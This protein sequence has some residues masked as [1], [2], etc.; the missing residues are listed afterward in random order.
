MELKNEISIKAPRER[1]FSALNDADIL[2]Q[3]IPGCEEIEAVSATQ[4]TATVSA[5]VGPLKARFK[6]QVT[7]DD[8]VPPESYTLKGEGRGGP[9][10]HAKVAAKV[11]LLEQ[12]DT[13]LLQYEVKA[14]IGGKL[15]QL[16]GQ[17]VQNTA[18]KL[19]AEFFKNFEN[20][21]VPREPGEADPGESGASEARDNG[22]WL[23]LGAVALVVLAW[24]VF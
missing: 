5:K 17:L 4:F 20:V 19:A 11:R 16:G 7:L 3:A 1:V 14:D 9:A 23:W 13:T 24:L 18:Q 8:I 22:R 15:A 12:G 21:L 2:K 6:G 10:G